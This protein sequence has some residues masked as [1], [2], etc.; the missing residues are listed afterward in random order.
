MLLPFSCFA[1][2]LP[3]E[4]D[5][6]PWIGFARVPGVDE[7]R[8]EEAD[9]LW[10]VEWIFV[11]NTE[12]EV[13]GCAATVAVEL[14]VRSELVSE[15]VIGLEELVAGAVGTTVTICGVAVIVLESCV[16]VVW[17]VVDVVA[18]VCSALW[19]VVIPR[20]LSARLS[21]GDKIS[22]VW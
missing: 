7:I 22:R 13:V 18:A 21:I 14:L 17:E 6:R 19:V 10:E 20:M 8:D 4:L 11:V 16:V 1:C 9:R 15:A 2:W 5:E 12:D 3:E